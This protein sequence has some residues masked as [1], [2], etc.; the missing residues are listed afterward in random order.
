MIGLI[1]LPIILVLCLLPEPETSVVI[2]A[3]VSL[4]GIFSLLSANG[5]LL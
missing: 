5:G 4:L 3:T 1:I 2:G